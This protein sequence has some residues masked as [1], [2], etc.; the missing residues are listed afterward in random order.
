MLNLFQHLTKSRIYETLKRVQGDISELFTRPS[1][2]HYSNIP[3]FHLSIVPLFQWFL[4]PFFNLHENLAM[5]KDTHLSC[6][7]GDH[8]RQGISQVGDSCCGPVTAP[9]S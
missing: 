1:I 3:S 8:N 6:L 9:K 2:F 7:F 4:F 5:V